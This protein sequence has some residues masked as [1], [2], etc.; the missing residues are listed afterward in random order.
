MNDDTEVRTRG[1]LR[2]LV[3]HALR[4]EIGIVGARLLY[5]TDKV[6]HAGVVMAAGG[7]HHQFRLSDASDVGPIGELSLSRS[8]TAVTAACVALRRSVFDEVGGLDEAYAVAFG[9]V[10]LCL[11]IARAGYR[12]ICTPFAELYHHESVSRGAEDTP[13][14][15]ARFTAEL[16]LLR[17]RWGPELAVDR[18]TSP[19]LVFAWDDDGTWG[20]PRP[21]WYPGPGSTRLLPPRL[22]PTA[23]AR[24]AYLRIRAVAAPVLP[25]PLF[26]S[27]FYVAAHPEAA[28]YRLGAYQHF[29]RYGVSESLNPNPYFDT[30]WYL[31]RYPDVAASG[32]N[33]LDHYF[34]FGAR[35][36]RDPSPRF[37]TRWYSATNPDV[38]AGGHHPLQHFL[39]LGEREGRKPRP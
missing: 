13:E 23:I 15:R 36:G 11:R 12:I 26:S 22:T 32:M 3:S 16:E 5:P 24:R 9:D 21:D 38:R 20:L 14:K 17:Q 29:R 4:P 8:V 34:R 35:D 19:Q 31:R 33:P 2:E 27:R 1:W 39:M 28:S 25:N 30:G 7:P 10:D 6:Q 37:S 18:F